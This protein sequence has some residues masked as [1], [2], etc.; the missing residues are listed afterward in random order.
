MSDKPTPTGILA[1][2]IPLRQKKSVYPEPFASRMNGR[3]K[4][5]LGEAFGLRNFGINMTEI[6]PGGESSLMN[7]HT[8]Q[9]EFIYILE[10]NPTLETEAGS[11]TLSPGMCAGF[12]AAGIAHHLINR[13]DYRVLY[14]EI[15]D[16]TEG[17]VGHYPQDDLHAEQRGGSWHFLHKD[18]RPYDRSG[19]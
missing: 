13:T 5:Q 2:D 14:L 6:A 9:D 8:M 1:T 11:E 4:R 3:S 18:G 7:R 16:R 15:G 10:G 17:D 19:N 12:P